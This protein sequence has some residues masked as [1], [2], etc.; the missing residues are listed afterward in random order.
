MLIPLAPKQGLSGV[1]IVIEYP[2]IFIIVLKDFTIPFDA[3]HEGG[4]N[5]R[6][7]LLIKINSSIH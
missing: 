5:S 7:L 4:V 2:I 1:T 6:I 3:G